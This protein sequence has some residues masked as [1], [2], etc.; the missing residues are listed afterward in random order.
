M[1]HTISLRRAAAVGAMAAATCSLV[2]GLAVYG[3]ARPSGALSEIYTALEEA[4]S[5]VDSRFVGDYDMDDVRDY[6]LTGYADGLGD[7]WTSYMTEEYY[8]SYLE[9][10]AD[11][12]IGIGVTVSAQKEDD[13]S[14]VLHV[15]SVALG[16]P[17]AEAGI[18][19]YDD[20]TAVDGQTI[21][22]LGGYESAVDA[23]LG[24]EG[25]RVTLTVRAYQ[26]GERADIAVTRQEYEQIHVTA[27]M[28]ENDVG[29]L[30]IERFT[31][32]TD[33]QFLDALEQLLEE[34]AQALI[35]DLRNNPGGRLTALVESL[36]ALLP[37]G[38]II[39]L[40]S[41]DGDREVYTSD[42]EEVTLPMAVL[43]NEDSYSAA[44]FFAAAL[45][46]YG[47][48]VVV[49]EQTCGKGYSQQ[50]FPLSGGGCLNISTHCYYTPNGESL[51][52]KGVTPDVAVSLSEDKLAR[53][54]VLED[55][56][57]D[58]LQAALDAVTP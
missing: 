13:G 35:F 56:E 31:D 16:S 23:I 8:Q 10:A 14:T 47:K 22:E 18:G 9:T 40:E 17:A 52:G 39:S 11:S 28:L 19:A 41:K 25:K 12:T 30:Y 42:A 27:R 53:F 46:E 44:E 2:T 20:I 5:I 24:E 45:Q 49:G 54:A 6:V 36:D 58:Q 34:G 55:S 50:S 15:E 57:D 7:R 26:T 38:D 33:E 4:Q 21:D 43:V 48:A 3:L 29:Y 37:E 1:K 32:Q 51:I